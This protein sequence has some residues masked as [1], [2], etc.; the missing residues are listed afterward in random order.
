MNSK[1]AAAMEAVQ[2]L[3]SVSKMGPAPDK[4]R[5]LSAKAMPD[6]DSTL[7]ETGTLQPA[8]VNDNLG[9]LSEQVHHRAVELGF[10]QPA[11]KHIPIPDAEA[12]YDS[13]A[14]FSEKDVRKDNRLAGQVGTT[15]HVYGK[16][17][18]QQACAAEVLKLLDTIRRSRIMH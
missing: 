2:W 3:R 5:N 9:S 11:Y 8:N 1:K 6:S 10:T 4:R 18:A 16:K 17:A 12:F 13:Y 7:S 14:Q 15:R